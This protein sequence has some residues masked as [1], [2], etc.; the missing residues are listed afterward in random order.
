MAGEYFKAPRAT[1]A[2]TTLAVRDGGDMEDGLRLGQRVVAGVAAERA[3]AAQRLELIAE[4][5]GP[6]HLWR[7]VAANLGVKGSPISKSAPFG[8]GKRK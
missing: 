4:K 8:G 6:Q 1:S 5:Q 3:F 2:Q 7:S